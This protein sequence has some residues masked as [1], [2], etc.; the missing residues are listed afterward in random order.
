LK[1]ARKQAGVSADHP[2]YGKQRRQTGRVGIP[3]EDQKAALD[4][5]KAKHP[6]WPPPRVKG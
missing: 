6:V 1:G 4:H 5:E 3:T 2:K